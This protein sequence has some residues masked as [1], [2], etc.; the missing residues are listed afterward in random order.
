[1]PEGGRWSPVE[2]RA[3]LESGR[4][5]DDAYTGPLMAEVLGPSSMSLTAADRQPH[6]LS[7]VTAADSR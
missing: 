5:P 6:D 3:F 7:A 2:Q 4:L 1:L